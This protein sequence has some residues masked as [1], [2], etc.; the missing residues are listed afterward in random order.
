MRTHAPAS[1]RAAPSAP[2]ISV[3]GG[4]CP[5][6]QGFWKNHPAV[7]PVDALTLGGAVYSQA[8]LLTI[9][10][11]P[12]Q[13]DASI[14]LAYQ[15]IA[16][17]LNIAA[18]SDPTPVADLI[19]QADALLAAFDG[20][21]PYGVAPSTSVGQ[22]MVSIAATLDDYNNERLTPDCG[23]AIVVEGPVTAIELN[24]IIIN[25]IRIWLGPDDPLLTV[26]Q[27]G[28]VLRVE[29]HY[30]EIEGVV[31]LVAAVVL[32]VGPEVIE[33]PVT[34]IRGNI[35]VINNIEIW[36]DPD[37]PLLLVIRIGDTLRIEGNYTVRRGRLVVVVVVL[38]FVF[39]DDD[40]TYIIID[41]D[42]DYDECKNPPPPWAPAH[43]W[44]RKCGG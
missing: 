12:A 44:R 4:E 11:T 27:I 38:L 9:L 15:L 41:D 29:G 2:P 14:I 42:D 16:A 8:E 10:H 24:I 33:G 34:E 5:L 19:A 37:D 3:G 39:D 31:V 30:E 35:V 32:F 43:G 13:G 7:W 28:D 25:E 20:K 1:G 6:S 40:E 22:Q 36:L 21:L 26:I 23:T 17:K 18:G